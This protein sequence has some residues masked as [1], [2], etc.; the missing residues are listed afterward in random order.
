MKK[1]Y[2]W[3]AGYYLKT[4]YEAMDKSKCQIVGIVD[5]DT[6]KQG[7][8]WE[9]IIS[10][11]SP[12][13]LLYAE[14]DYVIVSVKKYQAILKEC[15]DL[16][17]SE[18]KIILFW[19]LDRNMPCIDGDKKK[20]IE[21]EE[22]VLWL[23]GEINQCKKR[24]ENQPY[25]L[26]FGKQIHIKSSEELLCRIIE[27]GASLCRFGDGEFEIIRGRERSWFQTVNQNLSVRLREILNSRQSN[28]LIAVADNFGCLEKYT[29]EAAD[30]IRDYLSDNKRKEIVDLLDEKHVYYNAYVSRPY[31][32]YR[33]K[34]HATKIFELFKRIWKGRNVLIVEG[35]YTRTGVENDLLSGAGSIKRILCPDT[36]AF[37]YYG[38][39]LEAIYKNISE[40]ELV[41]LTLGP[42]ATVLAYDLSKRG[43]QALDIGQLDNEYEWYLSNA[44]QRVEIQGKAVAE[45]EWCHRPENVEQSPVYQ[46]QIVAEVLRK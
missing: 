30:G 20:I 16:G 32:M 24:I 9:G 10:I 36:D 17:I 18:D 34:N 26:G 44:M 38:E 33:D 22:K 42:T 1:V 11:E 19:K 41:L 21:L 31:M 6:R 4:V 8:T 37:D 23:Y 28:I 5:N 14:F 25:E 46:G 13:A 3:G 12:E 45:L 29:E 40:S 35:Q 2:I 43:I 15:L 7:K 27:K 39:I